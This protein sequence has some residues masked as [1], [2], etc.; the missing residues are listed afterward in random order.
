MVALEERYQES[1]IIM[2][3]DIK[4]PICDVTKNE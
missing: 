1:D 2:A 3:D 4:K